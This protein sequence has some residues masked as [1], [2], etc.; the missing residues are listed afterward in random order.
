MILMWA[1][2][3]RY[4]A[5]G[6]AAAAVLTT[7][8][9]STGGGGTGPQADG[10]ARLAVLA[11]F[12]PLQF[13]AQQ[14]GGDLVDVTSL[15]PP[16]A[17]PHDLE[18]SPRQ[19]QQVADADVVVVLSG[20]QPAVDEAVEAQDPAHLV[21]AAATPAV[22]AHLSEPTS[23]EA[24]PDP[25][26]WLDPTLLAAVA[27]DVAAA[28]AEAD[29]KDATAFQERADGLVADLTALDD[30]FSAGLATCERRV[31]VTAHDAFGYLAARYDLEQVGISGMDPEAEPSPARL[32]E[33]GE[34]ATAHG[35]T[36]LF[37]EHL[38]N[39]KVSETLASDLGI[40][41]AVLDPV[42]SQDASGTDYR[43]AMRQNLTVLREALGCT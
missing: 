22:A 11:S 18:L 12:Y 7:A 25:H 17:E 13:V 3:V 1:T 2:G 14:V 9:C 4:L 28:L 19:V 30:E 43:D 26:F 21:D 24:Q 16:G 32:K 38:L 6:V 10:A 8:G 15:T 31:V 29:P 27:T 42:E 41:T 20:F 5:G 40:T 36:T 23:D 39:P 37:T 35:V 34:V 33:I